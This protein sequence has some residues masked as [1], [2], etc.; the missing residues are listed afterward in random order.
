M[1]NSSVMSGS[2]GSTSAKTA[3]VRSYGAE[4]LESVIE[5]FRSNIPKYFRPVEEAGLREY[6]A[7]NPDEYFVMLLGDDVIGCGGI[8]L[9]PGD[10]P[11]VSL[12]WGMVRNDHLGRGFGKQ[13]TTMRI[14]KAREVYGPL[15]LVTSTSQ[16]TSGFY[17]RYGFRIVEHI[18]DGFAPG[19]DKCNMRLDLRT[20]P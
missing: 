12:C 2:G 17:E 9:N 16:H 11:T 15:P 1:A 19:I 10:D 13:L 3:R 7:A 14:Q 5:I 20:T 18:V 8:G 4:D 6:L